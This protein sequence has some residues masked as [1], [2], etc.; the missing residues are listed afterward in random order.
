MLHVPWSPPLPS[1][2]TKL[3]RFKTS[4]LPGGSA[5]STMMP[6][7]PVPQQ[8]WVASPFRTSSPSC[9]P[10]PTSTICMLH[11]ETKSGTTTMSEFLSGPS[12]PL[13]TCISLPLLPLDSRYLEVPEKDTTIGQLHQVNM[14]HGLSI[15]PS[16]MPCR[17][18]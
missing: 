8:E 15:T 3:S 4:T 9:L 13:S 11:P 5:S 16:C 12:S 14:P 2:V 18:S 17:E 6:Q 1:A 7:N 10:K